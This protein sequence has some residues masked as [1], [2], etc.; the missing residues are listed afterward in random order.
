MTASPPRGRVVTPLMTHF[1]VP[2]RK[3]LPTSF[4]DLGALCGEGHHVGVYLTPEA[5]WGA[6]CPHSA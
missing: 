1:K 3:G 6:N 5:S 4:W 2:A